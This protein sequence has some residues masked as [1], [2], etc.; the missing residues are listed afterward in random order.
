MVFLSLSLR[1]HFAGNQVVASR[2]V[3]TFLSLVNPNCSSHIFF[4]ETNLSGCQLNTVF[5]A[6]K[7][8]QLINTRTYT[9]TH[10]PTVVHGGWGGWMESLPGVFHMLQ[11]LE[12]IL[13]RVEILKIRYILRVVALLEA[14][15]VTRNGR[16]LGCH[17]GFHQELEIRFKPR[18]MA[19]FCALHEK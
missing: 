16:H 17:L 13:S 14:C 12:T 8:V 5:I 15:D 9:Q 7:L 2:N 3:G 11:Y 4:V 18:K 6:K 1:H 19:I 10:T